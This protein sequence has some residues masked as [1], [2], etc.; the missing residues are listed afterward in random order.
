MLYCMIIQEKLLLE[1][2]FQWRIV[3][4]YTAE[5]LEAERQRE[6]LKLHNCDKIQGFL[7]SRP[8]PA[9]DAIALLNTHDE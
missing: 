4:Q 9:D 3:S 1:I 6:Y 8:L 5:E 7:I 2:L